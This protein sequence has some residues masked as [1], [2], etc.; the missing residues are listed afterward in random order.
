MVTNSRGLIVISII[1]ITVLVDT[2]I[3]RVSV[4][5][6]GLAPHKQSIVIFSI[7]TLVYAISQHILLRIYGLTMIEM[8]VAHLRLVR[9]LVSLT[10]YALILILVLIIL[11]MTFTL[12]YSISLVKVVVWINYIMS[13]LMLG[14]LSLRFLVWFRIKRNA[15]VTSYAIAMAIL[16][17]NC[18]IATLYVT[19]E[20]TGQRG[21][22]YMR[23]LKSL[24]SIVNVQNE[25]LNSLYTAT[26]I[27]AFLLTWFATVLLLRHY[28]TRIGRIKYWI[29]VSIPLVYFMSQFQTLILDVFTPLR[30]SNPILFGIVYTLI[31]TAV[32]PVGGILFGIAFWSVARNMNH[33]AVKAY[34]M[35]SA[36]GLIL[37]FVSN[38][39]VGLT[40]APFPPFSLI[41][42]SFLGLSSYLL[43]VGI[44]SSAVSVANDSELRKTIRRSVQEQTSL[45]DNIGTS[46]MERQVL[47][48]VA[49]LTK[50]VSEKLTEETGIEAS[51][52][53]ELDVT[54]Y[55]HT[56]IREIE[57]TKKMNSG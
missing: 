44:Y 7:L 14:L 56:A 35:I 24:V 51:L 42:L 18:L 36:Y 1:I 57:R 10:Q 13:I 39:P 34:M 33:Q 2:S 32:K 43:Y 22:E 12:S 26:S 48:N 54:E 3:T 5:T 45:L 20:L 25:F 55:V 9:Q 41:T 11:Q 21:V 23:P 16:S 38:Q 17:L 49:N 8:G 46:E 27:I 52:Q 30:I 31:F 37:L 50:Q 40:L 19:S 29:L 4:Y 15:I 47:K 28:S 53:E 6:G